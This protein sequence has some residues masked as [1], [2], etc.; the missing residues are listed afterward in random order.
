[1]P[2]SVEKAVLDVEA[3]FPL[4][5]RML[6]LVTVTEEGGG[7]LRPKRQAIER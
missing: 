4:P 7:R 3:P 5:T 2:S 6:S 1:M